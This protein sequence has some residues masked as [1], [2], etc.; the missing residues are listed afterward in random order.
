MDLHTTTMAALIKQAMYFLDWLQETTTL[1]LKMPTD[2]Q[3]RK[4]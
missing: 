4:P 1:V 2:V 3:A